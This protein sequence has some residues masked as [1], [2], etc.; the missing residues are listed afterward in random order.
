MCLCMCIALIK[1]ILDRKIDLALKIFSVD[2]DVC[3][4]SYF[5]FSRTLS[6][7]DNDG[8][9]TCDEFCLAMHLSELARSGA[10]LPPKLPPELVPA[11]MRGRAG[12]MANVNMQAVP[13]SQP[14]GT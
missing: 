4:C 11:S 6:D 8:K 5:L 13:L 2:V 14:A 10:T 3:F 9:L 7:V 1:Y 12:S